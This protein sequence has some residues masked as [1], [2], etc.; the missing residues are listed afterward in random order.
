MRL[1]RQGKL[2]RT[3]KRNLPFSVWKESG[4]EQ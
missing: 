1:P 4:V 2:S 3:F